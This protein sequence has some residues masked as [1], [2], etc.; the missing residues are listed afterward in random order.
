MADDYP[1]R[2]LGWGICCACGED[3]EDE[4]DYD[5]VTRVSTC[6]TCRAR[7]AQSLEQQH[8]AEVF[9]RR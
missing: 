5:E 4:L 7:Q 9:A 8:A 3:C 1:D 2:P 6:P